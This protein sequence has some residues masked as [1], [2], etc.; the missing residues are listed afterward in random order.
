MGGGSAQAACVLPT[1]GYNYAF[2]AIRNSG[3]DQMNPK[4]S[5]FAAALALTLL[6]SQTGLTQQTPARANP[7]NCP[8]EGFQGGFTRGCPQRQYA[9]PSD[10]S[11]LM[12]ALPDKPYATP[13]S[14][15]RVLV[16]G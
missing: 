3:R 6:S 1:G 5:V 4:S 2:R 13:K 11:G 8:F 15:R 7:E 16:L 14:P 9:N 10:I 12:A